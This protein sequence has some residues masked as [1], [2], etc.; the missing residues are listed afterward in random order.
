MAA[1]LAV[2]GIAVALRGFSGMAAPAAASVSPATIQRAEGSVV[3]VRCTNA[4]M[5]ADLLSAALGTGFVTRGGIVTAS[6]VISICANSGPGSVSAGPF[7]VS[8]SADDPTHDLALMRLGPA[9]TA[10]PLPLAAGLPSAGEQLELIGSPG[11]QLG[12]ALEPIDGTVI[13]TGATVTLYSETGASETLTDTIVVAANGVAHGDSGGPAVNAAGEVVGVIEG[14][15]AD[16][17]YLTPAS[18]VA[19][20]IG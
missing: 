11:D 6:H 4:D 8:V 2:A 17:A 15:D 1:L 18:N 3:R 14:G 16:R 5:N 9:A 10:P 7:V 19:S 20:V 12:A 13:A